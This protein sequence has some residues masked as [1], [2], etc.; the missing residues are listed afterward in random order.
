MSLTAAAYS[1]S[2]PAFTPNMLAAMTDGELSR[3]LEIHKALDHL[4]SHRKI[5]SYYPDDGPHRRE[6]YAKHTEFFRLG[7]EHKE[8]LFLAGNRTG[9]SVAGAY[10]VTLHLTG[11][12][13]T[14]W[15]GR[16]FTGP[17]QALIAG[18]T[19]KTS[20]DILQQKMLGNPGDFGTGMIPADRI[21][22]TS[23]KQGIPDAVEMIHVKHASGGTSICQINS[24]DQGR[25]A[26]QGT[27]RDV[28]W[29]DE[30]CPDSVYTEALMRTMTTD[31]IVILTFTPLLGLTPLVLSFLPD[32]VPSE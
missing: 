3:L 31:G 11:E 17:I 8:R 28:I 16:R 30:E 18:D 14:W 12:Y 5:D 32:W 10:E 19:A 6:L 29:L 27:E 20:R 26:F 2:F 7:I 13:P 1:Q 23:P 15:E 21:M 25:D 9:K 22:R 24:Y 4:S